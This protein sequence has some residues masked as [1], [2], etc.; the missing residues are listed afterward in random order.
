MPVTRFSRISAANI[1]PNLFT[2][3][4]AVEIVAPPELSDIMRRELEASL[5]RLTGA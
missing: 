2:W 5:A 3:S 4:G 1:G